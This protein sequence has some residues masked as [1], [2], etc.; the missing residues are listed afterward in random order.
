MEGCDATKPRSSSR[1]VPP[2]IDETTPTHNLP[3]L[4]ELLIFATRKKFLDFRRYNATSG[5]NTTTAM[6]VSAP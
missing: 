3:S 5:K 4:P 6:V 1:A 2:A